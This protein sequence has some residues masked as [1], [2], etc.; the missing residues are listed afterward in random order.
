MIEENAPMSMKILADGFPA[1]MHPMRITMEDENLFAKVLSPTRSLTSE[2]YPEVSVSAALNL[3][4]IEFFNDY[5]LAF[6]VV[7]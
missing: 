2:R 1:T 7:L 3:N 4:L 6:V 5:P